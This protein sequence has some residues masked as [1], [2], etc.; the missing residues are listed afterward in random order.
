MQR[1]LKDEYVTYMGGKCQGCD[2]NFHNACY[3]FHHLE[4]EHK[5][6]ALS[7]KKMN[8]LES[9]KNELDKCV[10]V[11]T[12]CHN[13]AHR[14]MKHKSGFNNKIKGN[15]E[16]WRKNRRRKFEFLKKFSCETCGYDDSTLD[17]CLIFPK[18]LSTEERLKWK[19]YN[20]THWSDDYIAIL[21]QARVICTNCR[22]IE[23][24]KY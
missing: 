23:E 3:D 1:R 22:R 15:T 4:P 21:K 16:L 6:F 8:S 13:K 10:L 20:K 18:Y 24:S 7:V 17:L 12:I 5:D 9:V 19:K 2:R 14:I 11:C